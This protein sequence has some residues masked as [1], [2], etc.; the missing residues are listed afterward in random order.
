MDKGFLLLKY[1]TD[2]QYIL[3]RFCLQE[4]HE[5]L[6]IM[7][8]SRTHSFTLMFFSF[9]FFFWRYLETVCI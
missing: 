3:R 5:Q 6:W 1:N 8:D 7:N 9:S 4:R 2:I